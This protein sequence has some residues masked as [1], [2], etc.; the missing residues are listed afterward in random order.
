MEAPDDPEK[1]AW[2]IAA[3]GAFEVCES[4]RRHFDKNS[5][6][7]VKCHNPECGKLFYSNRRHTRT[8][9]RAARSGCL[10][11]CKKVWNNYRVWLEGKGHDP[12]STWDDAP[13]KKQFLAIYKP[14]GS[15]SGLR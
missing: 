3:P 14:R 6:Y 13:L 8:C 4:I 2:C 15:Q 12:K 1:T 10:S 11:G 7:L 9:H 5:L